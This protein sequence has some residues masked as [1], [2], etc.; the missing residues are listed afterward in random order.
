MLVSI[1]TDIMRY[2]LQQNS[3]WGNLRKLLQLDLW[4]KNK[5]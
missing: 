2:P 3:N 5:D 4:V 1:R